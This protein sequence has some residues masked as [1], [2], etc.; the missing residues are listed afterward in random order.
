MSPHVQKISADTIH[1]NQTKFI[2]V[3]FTLGPRAQNCVF[4]LFFVLYVISLMGNLSI[5]LAI[6]FDKQ[7]HVPMYFFLSSL[8]F[9]DIWFISST[10][11]KLLTILA[12]NNRVISI[13]GC[14]LQLYF[15]VSL[16]TIEFYLLAV[17]S[18]DRYVA[19]SHPLRY[20]TIITNK[21]CLWLLL[22]AWVFGF[23]TFIYPTILLFGLSFC[24]PYEVNHFFCDSSAI[25]KISCS[26]I[27]QFDMVFASFA[28]AVI[29]GSF[30]L[31]FISYC[32]ILF[33]IVMIPSTR[34]KIK[35]VS[36]CTSHFT[37]VSLVYGSAIFIY[38]RSV[39]SSSPDLNKIVALLNSVM[40]P[41]LNPFI[42]TLR[43]KQVKQVFRKMGMKLLTNKSSILLK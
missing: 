17:M 5:I 32:N 22:I 7:L 21:V 11:P 2:L 10:V 40:T 19:I 8:A 15:Y 33:T 12:Y 38:V 20:H 42:Y 6:W 36:T 14:I 24:G 29:M 35:A 3:G 4:L 13:S 30:C 9:L 34:G 25:V 27:H 23:T 37:V 26:D 18:V 28:S 31:T 43:N 39:D 1:V 16:G 41:V